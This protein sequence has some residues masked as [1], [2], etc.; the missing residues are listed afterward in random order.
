MSAGRQSTVGRNILN[1]TSGVDKYQK[2]YAVV[3]FHNGK[4]QETL[5]NILISPLKVKLCIEIGDVI[6][7]MGPES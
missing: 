3:L 7:V 5:N 2:L 4:Y 6:T 1:Q